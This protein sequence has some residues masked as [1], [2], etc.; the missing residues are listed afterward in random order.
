MLNTKFKTIMCKYH[1]QDKICPLGNKCHFA[2]GKLELRK[3]EDPLPNNTPLIA[4]QVEE[5]QD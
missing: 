3:K 2:H 1:E 4:A 5:N